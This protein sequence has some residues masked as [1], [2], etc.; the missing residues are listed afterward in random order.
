MEPAQ[1][2][3]DNELIAGDGSTSLLTAMTLPLVVLWTNE[4]E[5][6]CNISEESSFGQLDQSGQFGSLP[7]HIH[8]QAILSDEK[9][10]VKCQ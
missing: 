1:G 3:R 5:E 10:V 4:D 9:A 7:Q 2:K 6:W 8:A